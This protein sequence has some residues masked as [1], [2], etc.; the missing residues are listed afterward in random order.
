MCAACRTKR[1]VGDLVRLVRDGRRVE[2]D[3]WRRRGGRGVNLCADPSCVERAV[4]RGALARGFRHAVRVD[5][6]AL[7][8]S[9]KGAQ[10]A[11]LDGYLA[12]ARRG[13]ALPPSLDSGSSL[14]EASLGRVAD[15]LESIA[16]GPQRALGGGPAARLARRIVSLHYPEPVV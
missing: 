8:E 4:K 13:G 11:A 2:P 14:E 12:G 3:P 15:A 6:G 10:L 1:P 7:M 5:A 16:Q 9:L